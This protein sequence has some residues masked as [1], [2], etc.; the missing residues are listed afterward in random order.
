MS[1][2]ADGDRAASS[3]PRPAH[4]DWRRFLDSLQAVAPFALDGIVPGETGWF[5]E[6]QLEQVMINLLKN[7][8]EAGSPPSSTIV[9]VRPVRGGWAVEVRYD[10]KSRASGST[11]E[12]TLVIRVK[13]DELKELRVPLRATIG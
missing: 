7:A 13:D 4:V 6:S 5:D 10:G 3:Q 8:T 2:F 12:A 11:V 1:L 9:S